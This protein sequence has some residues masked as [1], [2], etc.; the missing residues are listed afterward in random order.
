MTAPLATD[1]KRDD[2]ALH[3]HV[4]LRGH[5]RADGGRISVRPH[6]VRTDHDAGRRAGRRRGGRQPP[7]PRGSDHRRGGRQRPGQLHRLGG[8]PV[9]RP[10]LGAPLGRPAVAARARHRPGRAVVHPAR[11]E[12]GPDRPHP[13]RRADLYFAA[14]RVRRDASAAV[15]PVH[16]HRLHPVDG[17]PGLGRL[18]GRRQL[19]GDRQ[20]LPR[21]HLR[22][23]RCPDRGRGRGRLDL[24]PPAPGR[25]PGRGRAA[26][27]APGRR[28]GS[29]P[30][31]FSSGVVLFGCR[32][33]SRARRRPAVRSL[34]SRPFQFR[35]GDLRRG[36]PRGG[37]RCT[38]RPSVPA[39]DGP[40][41]GW[42]GPSR[43]RSGRRR[44]G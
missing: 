24:L 2:A 14:G 35:G 22:Y 40:R 29:R 17:G 31:V 11:P 25:G 41:S 28:P 20:R 9:R 1:R 23:R 39:P 38:G 19:A 15:R 10:G 30:H 21:G 6:P 42:P 34:P 43:R 16:H 12:G 4:R 3:R 33:R 26:G 13:A 37:T 8:G 44:T 32:T 18:R 7:Q 5:I 36:P 27:R